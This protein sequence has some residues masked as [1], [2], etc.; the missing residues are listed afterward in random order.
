MKKKLIAL[1]LILCLL[2]AGC[3]YGVVFETAPTDLPTEATEALLSEETEAAVATEATEPAQKPKPSYSTGELD[4]DADTLTVHFI[5]VGQ[6][7]SA[8]IECGNAYA[9]IDAGY[10][11][12]GDT[13]VAYLE[14]LGV[15]RLNLVVGTH[16]HGDH[17]G[18]LPT[19]LNKIPADNI[20]FSAI[21]Y[22]NSTVNDFL[23]AANK[24]GGIQ[25]PRPGQ[26]FQLG[27]ATITVLGPVHSNYEDVNDI[28]LVLMVQ[29]GDMRFLFTGDMEKIAEDDLMDSGVDLQADVLK[30]GHHGSYSSTSYLFL[31]A[32]APTF[33]VISCGRANEYG[34]PHDEPV[35]RLKDAD[36]TIF[37]TDKMYNIVAVTDGT[38]ICF[39]WD[40]AYAKPWTPEE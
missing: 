20:W 9:L 39:T 8:L 17:I 3:E 22:T 7:D 11:E 40:N 12:S 15:Q 2:L 26:T 14:S 31:R 30:V 10:P 37:R 5:D 38:E 1:L 6:A 35:S 32:V 13:V 29:F 18:G 28:S 33:A 21:P 16:P 24:H 36:V 23:Y 34:H 25:Q 27:E 4:P 19:V